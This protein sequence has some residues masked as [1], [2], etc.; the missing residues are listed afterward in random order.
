MEWEVRELAAEETHAL[1]RAVSADGRTDLPS[2]RHE[3]DATTGAWH[4]G[5]VDAA[6]QVVAISSFYFVPHPLRPE[7]R[8]AVVLQF[9]A[10]D[11]LLQGR[12][13]GSAVMTEAIRRLK[14]TDAVLLWA[15]A[16]DAALHFYE[17]FGL[18][19]RRGASSPRLRPA[20]PTVSSS[21]G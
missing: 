19:L 16:R 3:L 14:A 11:P 7:A 21:S 4:L 20:G 15:N 2:M 8:P 5:A 1:R 9:M 17:R 12:G 6:S 13:I 18:P 10:V